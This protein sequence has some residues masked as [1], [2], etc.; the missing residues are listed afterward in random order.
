M[1]Q[2]LLFLLAFAMILFASACNTEIVSPTDDVL[3]VSVL[4]E[5]YWLE[6]YEDYS[7]EELDHIR[8]NEEIKNFVE[9]K[10]GF[11]LSDNV[12]IRVEEERANKNYNF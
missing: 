3:V 6:Y 11:K 10:I 1:K 9:N 5:L 12:L 4:N 8:T 2:G 7:S